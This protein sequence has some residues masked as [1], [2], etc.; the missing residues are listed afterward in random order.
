MRRE[1]GR[2]LTRLET[3]AGVNLAPLIVVVQLVEPSEQ[4]GGRQCRSDRAEANGRVWHRELGET[5]AEFEE[6]VLAE[7]ATLHEGPRL[8]I[9]WP[10][11]V[12]S[13]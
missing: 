3:R 8:V 5:E 7:V 13:A 6:R 9:M 4:F 11:S 2:R 10:D 1:A 12:G